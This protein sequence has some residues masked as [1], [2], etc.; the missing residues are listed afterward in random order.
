MNAPHTGLEV[1]DLICDILD[2]ILDLA[3][4]PPVLAIAIMIG[5]LVWLHHKA[6]RNPAPEVVR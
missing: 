3:E 2:G 4:F 6:H 1:P 5:V